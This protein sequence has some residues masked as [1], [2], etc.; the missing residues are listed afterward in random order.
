MFKENP[1]QIESLGIKESELS[2]KTKDLKQDSVGILEERSWTGSG[3]GGR[4][5]VLM[6]ESKSEPARSPRWHKDGA[7]TQLGAMRL[8]YRRACKALAVGVD[9]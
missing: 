5:G 9:A 1:R 2:I 7:R 6:P 3:A 8:C 4:T